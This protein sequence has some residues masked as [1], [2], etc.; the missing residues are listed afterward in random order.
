MITAFY[1]NNYI[2]V[3]LFFNFNIPWA[4]AHRFENI[5]QYKGADLKKRKL[6]ENFY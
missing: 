2:G 3:V 5:V 6:L 1:L 4:M